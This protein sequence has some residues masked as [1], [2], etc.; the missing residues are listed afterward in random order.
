MYIIL[1]VNFF[2]FQ[3]R[4]LGDYVQFDNELFV[5]FCYI[6]RAGLHVTCF[7]STNPTRGHRGTGFSVHSVPRGYS[8]YARIRVLGVDILYDA[9]Q[10]GP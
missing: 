10:L 8:G 6:H 5:W 9:A 1:F 4:L 7:R 2:T 3:R